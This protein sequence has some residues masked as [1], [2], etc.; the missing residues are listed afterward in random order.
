MEKQS[1]SASRLNALKQCSWAYWVQY[2]YLKIKSGDNH[3]NLRGGI[4]HLVFEML[5][6]D[7][8][9]RKE[10]VD[11][12][13]AAKTIAVVPSIH[14]YV[15]KFFKRHNVT[16]YDNKDQHNFTLTNS[17]ILL[18]LSLD[19]YSAGGK[20]LG[21]ELEIEYEGA[22]FKITG[23]IDQLIQI[24]DK[25][26]IRDWKTS[27]SRYEGDEA[28]FNLQSLT[29]ALWL[30]RV[31]KAMCLVRFIFLRFE[32][33]PYLEKVYT[34]EELEGFE[35]YLNDVA[36]YLQKFNFQDAISNTAYDKGWLSD[37][38]FQGRIVC[39]RTKARGELK[40]NGKL[41]WCCPMKHPGTYFAL[42]DKEGKY[43]RGFWERPD[44]KPGEFVLEQEYKG[45]Y[46]FYPQNYIDEKQK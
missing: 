13:L 30:Y 18:G 39:G 23:F 46:A 20:V 44:L 7:K 35:V 27:A 42:Y 28:N 15:M 16:E 40:K 41:A 9:K 3:G 34:E 2:K 4:V 43:L 45:C 24:E 1:V 10:Y 26:V 33:N 22:N 32:Q 38:G 17:M 37:Q 21:S 29:Y 25:L 31:K 36:K 14:R 11:L 19:F 6:K 12:I 8:P 5:L